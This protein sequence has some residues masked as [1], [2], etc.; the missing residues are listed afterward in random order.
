MRLLAMLLSVSLVAAP[1]L[2]GDVR[3]KSKHD[4]VKLEGGLEGHRVGA[5]ETLRGGVI[6]PGPVKVTLR[7]VGD[8]KGGPLPV[9]VMRDGREVGRFSLPARVKDSVSDS[10]EKAGAPVDKVVEVPP[11]PHTL[12]VEVGPGRGAVMVSFDEARGPT[13]VAK[14]EPEPKEPVKVAKADKP[15]NADKP[16]KPAKADKTP[17]AEPKPAGKAVVAA[18]PPGKLEDEP[19][20]PSQAGKLTDEEPE[21][22]AEPKIEP[23]AADPA[24][25]AAVDEKP[26]MAQPPLVVSKSKVEPRVRLLLGPRLGAG[27]QSQFGAL[28]P[29]L[30]LSARYVLLGDSTPVGTRGLLVGLS[31]DFL[32]YAL[33][34]D[35]GQ[36]PLSSFQQTVTTMSIPILAELTWSFGDPK[37]ARLAPY[38]GLD[39]GAAVGT[40]TSE[41]PTGSTSSGFGQFAFGAHLGLEL[42]V[43]SNRLGVEARYVWSKP[44]RVGAVD[45]VDV[46]GVLLQASWRFGL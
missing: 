12:F 33:A 18:A 40:L 23:K 13:A 34:F 39:V 36:G 28:G 43:G 20:K 42:P 1:A 9:K 8:G 44:G 24:L 37:Q 15:A 32:R 16:D 14:V 29:A 10:A 30:G 17:K 5:E 46:G 2:A 19:A 22:K 45:N 6:G 7:R 27:L 4:K 35:V 3:V 11:G 25:A 41:G 26:T 31:A 21:P 38:A